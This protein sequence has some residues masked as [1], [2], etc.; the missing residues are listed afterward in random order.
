MRCVNSATAHDG[1]KN[2]LAEQESWCHVAGD[3]GE[4]GTVVA[5]EHLFRPGSTNGG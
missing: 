3:E 1:T 5:V 4:V 2:R